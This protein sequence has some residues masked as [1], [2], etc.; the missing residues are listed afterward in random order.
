VKRLGGRL[1]DA[2]VVRRPASPS[3]VGSLQLTEGI[4]MRIHKSATVGSRRSFDSVAALERVKFS[5]LVS[6]GQNI[7]IAPT[8]RVKSWHLI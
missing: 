8:F 1:G 5:V 4:S 7:V 3:T 6:T 2:H